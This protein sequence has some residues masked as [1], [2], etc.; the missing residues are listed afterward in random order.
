MATKPENQR[1]PSLAARPT[2]SQQS[3]ASPNVKPN[4]MKAQIAKDVLFQSGDFQVST[5]TICIVYI[6]CAIIYCKFNSFCLY[7]ILGI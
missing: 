2:Q 1:E 6:H 7:P 5:W 4:G 3:A